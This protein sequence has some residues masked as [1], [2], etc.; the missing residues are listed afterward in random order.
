MADSQVRPS[1]VCCPLQKSGM[2]RSCSISFS[3]LNAMPSPM[4]NA[5]N[6]SFRNDP[7]ARRFDC[8]S[9]HSVF[10]CFWLSLSTALRLDLLQLLLQLRR[11]VL[12]R[13]IVVP[14][15]LP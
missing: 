9:F 5:C 11:E 4:S 15:L 10:L 2:T 3:R 7:P 1:R 8:C 12:A 14:A 6:T 13:V